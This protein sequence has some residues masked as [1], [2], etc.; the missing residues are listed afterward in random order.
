MSTFVVYERATGRIVLTGMTAN[1]HEGRMA[2]S[3]AERSIQGEADPLTQYVNPA[4]GRIEPRLRMPLRV[5]GGTLSGL[6]AGGC[7]IE[8]E[9]RSYPVSDTSVMLRF[10]Q[11]GS[12]TVKVS[13]PAFLDSAIVV[14]A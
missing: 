11:P 3:S 5:D 2:R 10:D 12:Y 8:I 14:S 13:A 7:L 6:P 4:T 1:G 9:G